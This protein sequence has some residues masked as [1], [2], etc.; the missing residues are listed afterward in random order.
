MR[1]AGSRERMMERISFTEPGTGEK[2]ELY[3][4]EQTCINGISYLLATE[5]EE[6]DSVAYIFKEIK[7]ENEDVI[8]AMVEE[9]VELNV[10]SRVFAEMLDDVDFEC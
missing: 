7:T 1:A 10:I 2:I 9:D 3:V 8:Y 6:E 5:E 4:L